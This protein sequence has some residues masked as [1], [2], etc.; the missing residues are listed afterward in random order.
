[1]RVNEVLTA[2]AVRNV[3][4]AP[5]VDSDAPVLVVVNG[6]VVAVTSASIEGGRVVLHLAE[7]A[8]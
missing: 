4:L 8:S 7:R 5:D 6:A 1:M 3:L 2:R